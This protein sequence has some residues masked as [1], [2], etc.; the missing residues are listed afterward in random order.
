VIAAF[1]LQVVVHSSVCTAQQRR[2][3]IPQHQILS[4]GVIT[5]ARH[6]MLQQQGVPLA[7]LAAL[8]DGQMVLQQLF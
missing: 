5:T 8:K 4:R 7:A 6:C 3:G 2:W 1:Y